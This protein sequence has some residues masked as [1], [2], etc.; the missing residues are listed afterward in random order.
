MA[1][2]VVSIRDLRHRGG[3]VVDQ[4][5]AGQLITITRDG[6][7]VAELRALLPREL[8]ATQVLERWKGAPAVDVAQL[9]RDADAVIDPAL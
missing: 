9:R 6:R 2:R 4:A 7:P 8:T 3:D 1:E 5:A